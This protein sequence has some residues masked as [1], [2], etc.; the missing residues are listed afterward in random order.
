MKQALYLIL[1]TLAP[2]R[3]QCQLYDN[4]WVAGDTPLS[5]INFDSANVII[6]SLANYNL[7]FTVTVANICDENGQLLYITNG[8]EVYDSNGD[9]LQNGTGINPCT[10]TAQLVCCGLDIPQAALFIPQPGNNRYYYLFHFT[11]DDTINGGP[12]TLYYSIVD[13]EGNNGKGAVAE[14]NISILQNTLLRE[15]GMTA[16]KHANGRDYWIIMG[17][18]VINTFYKFLVTPKGVKGP[19]TQSIGPGFPLPYDNA[20][21]RFSQ[22][23]SKY[24]TGDY[25]GPVLVMDF[26]RCNGVFS[27]PLT[28]YNQ[29]CDSPQTCSASSS[30][31]ISPNNRF[32]YVA[33]VT[34]LNQYDLWAPNLQNSVVQL[35]SDSVDHTHTGELNM[36]QLSPDGKIYISAWN[37]LPFYNP[38][39]VINTPNAKGDSCNFKYGSQPT[40]SHNNKLPNM[41]NYRLGPLAGSGCDTIT[42]I[43]N[44]Q[45]VQDDAIRISPNPATTTCTLKTDA[46]NQMCSAIVFDAVGRQVIPLFYNQHLSTFDFNCTSL[47]TGLYFITVKDEQGK[48]GVLKL[49]KQ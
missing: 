42:A 41:I 15:G 16:C 21:S 39:H 9:T 10:Y 38:L 23:G 46:P 35:Y 30:V 8:V 3:C 34:N 14:K 18:S 33:D 17:A 19:F 29:G 32:V 4:K 49:V 45:M 1:L 37:G 48:V 22:D 44:A 28:I 43:N 27:N 13:K 40:Y 36:L 7:R 6:D 2:F 20:Y 5:F 11:D 25:V 31:E 47:S 26:D 24:V 12:K